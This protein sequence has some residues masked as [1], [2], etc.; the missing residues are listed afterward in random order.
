MFPLALPARSSS[1]RRL[2]LFHLNPSVRLVYSA[3][4]QTRR[5]RSVRVSEFPPVPA[6]AGFEGAGDLVDA[7][8]EFREQ[9]RALD[10]LDELFQDLVAHTRGQRGP[11]DIE[12][13]VDDGFVDDFAVRRTRI[14]PSGGGAGASAD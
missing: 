10:E 2:G 9:R 13:V 14:G 6:D 11:V 4:G 3:D 8:N 7:D 5:W 1:S 12:R